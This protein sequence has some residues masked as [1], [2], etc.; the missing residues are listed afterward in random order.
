MYG[1]EEQSGLGGLGART[2]AGSSFFGANS[3]AMNRSAPLVGGPDQSGVAIPSR[4]LGTMVALPQVSS[5][6]MQ[7]EAPAAQL[8]QNW[9]AVLDFHNSP[10]PWIL[11]GLLAI[12]GWTHL[13]YATSRGRR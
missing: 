3:R 8:L 2:T 12:Y 4:G 9:R 1:V 5:S 7:V 11:I 10:A 6:G 13:S